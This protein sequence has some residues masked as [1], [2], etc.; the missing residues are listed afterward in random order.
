MSS[1][2]SDRRSLVAGGAA[3]D[4][5]ARDK[6]AAAR[7]W[8]MKHKP[9]FGVLARA[10]R[11]VPSN[12]TAAFRLLPDDSLL[13]L[14]LSILRMSFPQLCARLAHLSLHAALG[15]FRRRQE[16]EERRWNVAH[17]LAIEPLLDAAG[18]S[19]RAK[20]V[21]SEVLAAGASAEAYFAMLKP[22]A[23]P[24]AEWCDLCDSV[25]EESPGQHP[26]GGSG[27]E[28]SKADADPKNGSDPNPSKPESATESIEDKGRELEWKLRLVAALEEEAR[29]GGRTFGDQPA[30]IEEMLRARI[31]PTVPWSAALQRSLSALQRSGRSFLRPSRRM[32]ALAEEESSWPSTVTMPGRRIEHAGLLAVVVDTSASITTA[33]LERFLTEV[34]SVATAEGI[35]EVRLLQADAAVTAD[36]VLFGAELLFEPIAIFGRGGSNFEPALMRLQADAVEQGRPFTAVYLSDLDGHFGPAPTHVDVLWVAPIKPKQPPPFGTLLLLEP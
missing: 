7:V 34:V 25:P 2:F 23:E 15:A 8:L 27:T 9:F 36:R 35:D 24:E 32:S 11:L 3:T 28:A 20:D 4:R 12:A 6:L 17:D 31:R 14:P 19:C 1:S 30:W 21:G 18:L 22:S 5:Q 29:S 10:F 33:M 26:P 13:Y 16:R